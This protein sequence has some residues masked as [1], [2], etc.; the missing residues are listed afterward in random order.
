MVQKPPG[1]TKKING[2]FQLILIACPPDKR[3][4]DIDNLSKAVLDWC[5]RVGM[6]ANDKD[7]SKKI[8]WWGTEE[9]APT[10]CRIVITP[11]EPNLEIDNT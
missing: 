8:T 11:M 1:P 4:R 7:C 3:W 6:I 9:E 10:G 2:K 5:E